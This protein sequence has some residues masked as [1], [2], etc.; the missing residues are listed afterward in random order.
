MKRPRLRSFRP[1][2][3]GIAAGLAFACGDTPDLPPGFFLDGEAAPIVRFLG[4]LEALDGTP[5]A[6]LAG[7]ARRRLDGCDRVRGQTAERDLESLAESLRC[8]E[9]GDPAPAIWEAGDAPPQV[10]WSLETRTGRHL[11]GGARFADDGTVT[12][13]AELP[14]LP[15][16]DPL[17]LL[18]P[19]AE[20]PGPTR[21]SPDGA[22]IQG[23]FKADQGLDLARLVPDD[24]QVEGLFQ[25]KSQVLAGLLLEG[26][27]ELALYEP[28]EGELMPPLALAVDFTHRKAAEA[29]WQT[30]VREVER[31]WGFVAAP[32]ALD[33]YEGACLTE[34]RVLPEL[35]PCY[36]FTDDALVLGWNRESLEK[37]LGGEPS[38]EHAGRSRLVVELGGL[39]RADT[40]LTASLRQRLGAADERPEP[41]AYPWRRLVLAGRRDG[42]RYRLEGRLEA[43]EPRAEEPP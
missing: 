27:W 14:V 38:A 31:V 16:E 5:L 10:V 26:S 29:A 43:E 34:V 13:S 30:Y 22:L 7:S 41:I 12:F 25:L 11:V 33:R 3:V 9:D 2:I 28:A 19:S 18:M 35:A 6:K 36:L 23:R 40:R 39:P 32:F 17:S 20:E 15:P 21:L 42:D 37:A 4:D 24:E 8:A 1:G